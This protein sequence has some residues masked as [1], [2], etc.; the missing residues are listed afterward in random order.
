MNESSDQ[1]GYQAAPRWHPDRKLP[2][3]GLVVRHFAICPLS[4]RVLFAIDTQRA[5]QIYLY[6]LAHIPMSHLESARRLILV[7][8]LVA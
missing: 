8:S 3:V 1:H 2:P 6:M 5:P 4:F 7:F